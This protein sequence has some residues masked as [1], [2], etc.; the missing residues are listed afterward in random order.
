MTGKLIVL[1]IPSPPELVKSELET[2]VSADISFPNLDN[3]LQTRTV[4]GKRTAQ[5]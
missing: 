5:M 1:M 2:K 3:I 4:S